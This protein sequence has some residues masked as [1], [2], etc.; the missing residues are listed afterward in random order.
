MGRGARSIIGADMLGSGA[1]ESASP[2]FSF[3]SMAIPV[4][5][6]LKCALLFGLGFWCGL[7]E[8]ADPLGDSGGQAGVIRLARADDDDAFAGDDI[9]ADVLA[10]VAAAHFGDDHHLAEL[11]VDLHI[12]H[13]D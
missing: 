5:S 12:P 2:R 8:L 13:A 7:F 10:V 6:D 9:L 11:A 4:V 1:L 3:A